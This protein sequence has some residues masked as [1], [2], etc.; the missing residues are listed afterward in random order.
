LIE[1]VGHVCK[2][3]TNIT[4]G[5]IKLFHVKKQT[6]KQ[7]AARHLTVKIKQR[8]TSA[9]RDNDRGRQIGHPRQ[10]LSLTTR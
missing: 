4:T 3:C 1:E 2:Y 7:D 9:N 10:R 5:N 8:T 6:L